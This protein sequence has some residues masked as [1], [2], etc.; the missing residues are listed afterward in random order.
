[1]GKHCL[2]NNTESPEGVIALSEIQR[3]LIEYGVIS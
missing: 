3:N 2:Q 1:M